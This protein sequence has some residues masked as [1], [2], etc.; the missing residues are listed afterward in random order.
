MSFECGKCK[1][2]VS[3]SEMVGMAVGQL[4]REVFDKKVLDAG[5]S[6]KPFSAGFLNGL[7][8]NCTCGKCDWKAS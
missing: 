3:N 6:A 4:T 2:E 1:K 5:F 8:I 7:R